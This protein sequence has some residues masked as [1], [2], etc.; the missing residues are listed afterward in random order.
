MP[1]PNSSKMPPYSSSS[2]LH[3]M[4]A[5][6]AAASVLEQGSQH[7]QAD[8]LPPTGAL[9]PHSRGR[10]LLLLQQA[11]LRRTRLVCQLLP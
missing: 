5:W 6:A 2:I 10:E 1:S 8:L 11:L 4:V 9:L 7:L 3:S